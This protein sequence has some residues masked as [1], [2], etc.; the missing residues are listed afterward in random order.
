MSEL[1][2]QI[3]VYEEEILLI[4]SLTEALGLANV[5]Q[6]DVVWIDEKIIPPERGDWQP[7]D[8]QVLDARNAFK[9][10]I[11]RFVWDSD[12]TLWLINHMCETYKLFLT[13]GMRE[14]KD[15]DNTIGFECGAIFQEAFG[16]ASPRR[17][18][19]H[20]KRDKAWRLAICRAALIWLHDQD[21]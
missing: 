17:L 14:V 3:L 4:K 18:G 16:S 20:P 8:M 7:P 2:L 15:G 13:L 21:K 11:P 5:E 1:D 9:R 10:I 6:G 19:D 12:A